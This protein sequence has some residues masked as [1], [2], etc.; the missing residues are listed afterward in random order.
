MNVRLPTATWLESETALLLDVPK[1]TAAA[2][3][4]GMVAGFQFAAVFQSPLPGEASQVCAWAEAGQKAGSKANT[5]SLGKYTL[6]RER[7]PE[8]D[9]RPKNKSASNV[10][11]DPRPLWRQLTQPKS[12]HE[13]SNPSRDFSFFWEIGLDWTS[14]GLDW[15]SPF[16]D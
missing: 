9:K 5:A 10:C 16:D 4:S 3:E 8:T 1:T 14:P 2:R 11:S 6:H 7:I 12:Q 13:I 15:A